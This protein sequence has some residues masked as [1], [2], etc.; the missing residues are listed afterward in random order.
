M[1]H[2]AILEKKLRAL[3]KTCCRSEREDLPPAAQWLRDNARALYSAVGEAQTAWHTCKGKKYAALR[4][5]CQQLL[6]REKGC[7]TAERLYAAVEEQQKARAFTVRELRALPQMLLLCTVL[8]LQDVL[9]QIERECA[10]YAQGDRLARAAGYK[11]SAQPLPTQEAALCRAMEVLSES[12]D[13]QGLKLMEARLRE[14]ELQPGKVQRDAQ[15][16]LSET[17]QYMGGVVETLRLLPKLRWDSLMPRLSVASRLLSQE[18]T[19]RRMDAA[20]RDLYLT[21]V[22]RIAERAKVP[23]ERVCETA[24]RLAQA[25]NGV[26]A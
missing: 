10:A 2:P 6:A 23:E 15:T 18:R 9:P 19:F 4:A 17:A 1:T 21:Q 14:K 12:G 7:L 11:D 20:G 3:E 22:S 26:E 16:Q 13:V 24:L 8:Q 25:G 5:C